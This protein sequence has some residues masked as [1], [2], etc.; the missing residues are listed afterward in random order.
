MILQLSRCYIAYNMLLLS[1]TFIFP[2]E[3][4][5]QR[6]PSNEQRI[7]SNPFLFRWSKRVHRERRSVS[8]QLEGEENAAAAHHLLQPAD[9]AAGALVPA[10]PV[11][12]PARAGR[13]R[14]QPGTHA[15]AGR[16]A[17][18]N[19]HS[20]NTLTEHSRIHKHA[21]STIDKAHIDRRL[22]VRD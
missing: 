16:S 6:I 8:G 13:A 3:T 9:T 2:E 4:Y 20:P 5:C 22:P 1:L 7:D 21:T 17:P 19:L 14:L 15:D 18:T 11:P 12:G 10:Q